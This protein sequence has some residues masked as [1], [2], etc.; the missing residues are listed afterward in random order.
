MKMYYKIDYKDLD[1]DLDMT[2]FVKA[3]DREGAM[4]NFHSIYD[5]CV[6]ETCE[7]AKWIKKENL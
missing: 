5:N 7:E 1:M 4:K 2:A 6:I 3:E